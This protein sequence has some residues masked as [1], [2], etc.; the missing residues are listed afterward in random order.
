MITP[1]Q[2]TSARNIPD[3]AATGSSDPALADAL[4][5]ARAAGH[6]GDL[7]GHRRR[8]RWTRRA[9]ARVA[10]YCH[11]EHDQARAPQLA[12]DPSGVAVAETDRELGDQVPPQGAGRRRARRAPRRRTPARDRPRRAGCRRT[13]ASRPPP[14]RRHRRRAAPRASAPRP[15]RPARRRRR[16]A[17][18]RE[19]GP[20]TNA[21]QWCRASQCSLAQRGDQRPGRVLVATRRSVH[22]KRERFTSISTAASRARVR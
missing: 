21:E 22:R 7:R 12:L 4:D 3:G 2:R 9:A 16:T 15:C 10:A 13:T 19:R 14:R 6:L 5:R 1:L 17:A 20:S 11:V 18:A 8:G